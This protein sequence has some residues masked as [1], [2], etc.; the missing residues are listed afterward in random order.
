MLL[1]A[2]KLHVPRGAKPPIDVTAPPPDHFGTWLDF[3][4]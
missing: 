4:P 3:V 1:H 2:W